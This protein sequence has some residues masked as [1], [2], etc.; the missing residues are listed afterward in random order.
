MSNRDDVKTGKKSYQKPRLDRVEL[1]PEEAV[2]MSC[3]IPLGVVVGP[4]NANCRG[5][6]GPICSLHAS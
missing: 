1:V 6:G 4:N 5:I 2:L 3:K